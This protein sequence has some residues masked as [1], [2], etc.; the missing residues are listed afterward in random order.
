MFRLLTSCCS[1]LKTTEETRR[2]VTIPIIGLNNSGKTVLV[3]AFQKLLPSKTDH[4]MKSELT[5]LLL[6]EYELSIYDLN[7]DLKGREAWPNYYAQAHG[8]VF[9]LDSSDIRRMQEVK[10][11]LTHLL[12][13]KRVAGKPILLLANKQD[14]KKALMPCDIIDYLLLKKLVKE[15]KCP[16]RVE[17][18]SAI[19][20]LERRNHQPIVEGLR[21]LLAVINTCQL[22]PTSSISISKNNTGSGERC[23]SHSLSTRTGMSKEKRQHLEQRPTEAKPLKSILQKEG[24][25][26]RPKKNMSVT[27]ALDEP[28][29]EGEC[30]RRTRVQ[31]TTKF[32]YN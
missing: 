24:T 26:L 16:C 8:L 18:C 17:P 19:R 21:W 15:N 22:P 5:T 3:E 14:K 20:N 6:D 29:K 2:N 31:N 13:D 30:S 1:W 9:V 7:G 11:I 23:S 25:R 12:S 4:C 28:M 32:H 27:F 10:I